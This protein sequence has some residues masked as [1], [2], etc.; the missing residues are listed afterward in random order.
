[1]L[2]VFV[3]HDTLAATMMN[4]LYHFFTSTMW[5]YAQH[6]WIARYVVSR[7]CLTWLFTFHN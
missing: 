7:G 6:A 4:P 1:L 5:P 3:I 2:S